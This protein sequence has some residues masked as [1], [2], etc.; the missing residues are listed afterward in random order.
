MAGFGEEGWKRERKRPPRWTAPVPEMVCTVLTRDWVIAGEEGP[1]RRDA[2]AV[3]R[4]ARPL[5][6]RY[7][8]RVGFSWMSLRTYSH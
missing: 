3:V 1:M 8:L 2:A 4:D 5:M 7:S 6:G